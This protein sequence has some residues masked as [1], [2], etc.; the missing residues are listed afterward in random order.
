MAHRY[1]ALLLASVLLVSGILGCSSDVRAE[2]FIDDWAVRLSELENPADVR[3]A[4]S[5]DWPDLVYV[6]RLA[7][8][9]WIAARTEYSCDGGDGF[10][11]TVFVDSSGLVQYQIG[12]HFCG[13]DALDYELGSI[14]A[15]DLAGFYR[16]LGLIEDLNLKEW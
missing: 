16:A 10:D 12:H 8:G 13:H 15:T 5:V 14:D 11:A 4:P 9:E 6:R 1:P 3:G 7:N 2:R